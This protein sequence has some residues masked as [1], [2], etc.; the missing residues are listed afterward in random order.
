MEENAFRKFNHIVD[1]LSC[2]SRFSSVHLSKGENALEHTGKVALLCLKIA[3]DLELE[4]FKLDK[5]LLFEKALLHDIEES[6]TGDIISPIKYST[7]DIKKAFKIIEGKIAKSIFNRI[8]L[9]TNAYEIWLESKEGIEGSIVA[10]ID[11]ISALYKIDYEVRCRGNL[12]MI[13]AISKTTIDS[14]RDSFTR[15][16]RRFPESESMNQI[17]IEVDSLCSR[18]SE[19]Y[20]EN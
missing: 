8:L 7:V 1:K 18:V 13:D 9:N 19:F 10:F 3:K 15:M 20:Y 17:S 12:S 11:K 16:R 14:A 6:E 5:G 2:V 4:G